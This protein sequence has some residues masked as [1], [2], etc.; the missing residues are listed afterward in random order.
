M[1]DGQH[2]L[3]LQIA[4]AG[5]PNWT[6]RRASMPHARAVG[7]PRCKP[8]RVCSSSGRSRR[9]GGMSVARTNSPL[10]PCRAATTV[11]GPPSWRG[12]EKPAI[13]SWLPACKAPTG[14][15]GIEHPFEAGVRAVHSP[16]SSGRRRG[17]AAF[18]P[19]RQRGA[20]PGLGF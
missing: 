5:R 1:D 14:D 15:G 20:P 4:S 8:P 13:R 2:S 3:L 19:W 16:G 11:P 10:P 18:G 9:I 17:E 7:Q 6:N 12:W